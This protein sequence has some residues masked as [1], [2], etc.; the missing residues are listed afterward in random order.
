MAGIE[1]T[2]VTFKDLQALAIDAVGI[3]KAGGFKFSALPKLLDSLTKINALI[4]DVPQA[5]PEL[6]D[7]D[8]SEGIQLATAAFDLVKN[9]IAAVAA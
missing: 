9:V 8:A 5:L 7:L 1:A 4:K 6:K 2:L 3:V